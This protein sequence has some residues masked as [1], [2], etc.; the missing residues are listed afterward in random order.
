MTNPHSAAGLR[1]LRGE[2]PI[3]S[4]VAYLNSC[5]LGALS[6]S[7]ANHLGDFLDEWHQLGASGWYERWLGRIE[8]LR[9]R[10]AAF[11]G[12]APGET[13]ILPTA[14]T[15]LHAV[16][17]AFEKVERERSGRNGGIGRLRRSKIVCTELDFPTLAYQWASRTDLELV[18]L[19][20]ED[21][22]G[23]ELD[24]FAD[25]VDRRTLL[26]ATSHVFFTTGFVQDLSA[27]A[28]IAHRAGARCLVDGYQGAKH[29]ALVTFK[30]NELVAFEHES[31][32]WT[33]TLK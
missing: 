29:Q 24:Q 18:I 31:V 8:E 4:R 32:K 16:A 11:W 3:L 27:L 6:T 22:L 10:V 33:Q 14:S 25:A 1:S 5:S 23:I 9:A 7:A 30:T 13:A 12:S 21:G 28:E 2:F 26:L 17:A 20:S 19:K 15:A